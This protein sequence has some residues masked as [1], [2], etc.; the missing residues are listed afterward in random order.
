VSLVG[1][2]DRDL[3]R[4]VGRSSNVAAVEPDGAGL[5]P[6]LEAFARAARLN[7]P[8][9]VVGADPLSETAAQWRDLWDVARPGDAFETAAGLAL[10]AW[11]AG[12]WELPDYYV[13]VTEEAHEV[14]RPHEHDFHL[15]ALRSQRPGR[16][17]AIV[18][19][20][21]VGRAQRVLS[22][23]S[24]LPQGPWWP[25]LDGIVAAARAFLPERIVG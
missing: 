7:S 20:E 19:D 13:V 11:R 25:P 2:Y 3:P 16:V 6:A 24:H 1:D 15:G 21:N 18:A 23:L 8:Y 12:R 17:V 14:G 22:A 9:V 4:V 10:S 5:E